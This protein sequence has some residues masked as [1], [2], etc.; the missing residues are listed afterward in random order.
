MQWSAVTPMLVAVSDPAVVSHGN[1]I[2]VIGGTCRGQPTSSVQVYSE[3]TGAWKYGAQLGTGRSDAA[4]VVVS[5]PF[6]G[7]PTNKK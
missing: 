1:E 3:A 4:A 5:L 7:H 2:Y 6:G